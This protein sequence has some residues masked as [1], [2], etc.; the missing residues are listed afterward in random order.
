MIGIS[1]TS[2]ICALLRE[3]DMDETDVAVVDV[4]EER[5]RV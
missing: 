4:E 3:K 1:G 2:G 5:E